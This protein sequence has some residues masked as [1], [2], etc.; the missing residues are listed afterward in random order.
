MRNPFQT[1]TEKLRSFTDFAPTVVVDLTADDL[2]ADLDP[3]WLQWRE[4]NR[5]KTRIEE[6]IAA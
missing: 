5:G 1:I 4:E 6:S 3:G 2:L